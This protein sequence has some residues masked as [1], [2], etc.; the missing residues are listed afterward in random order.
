VIENLQKKFGEIILFWYNPNIHPKEEYKRRLAV[1]RKV[2]RL[3]NLPLIE[4]D[5]DP[6]KWFEAAAGLENEPEGGRR[7]EI[8]FRM[9]LEKTA[10]TAKETGCNYF[11]ATLTVSPRKPAAL[12]NNIGESLA[13]NVIFLAE[14][15]KKEEGFKKTMTEAKKLNLYRQNYCGCVF[16]QKIESRK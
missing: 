4:G 16:S 10:Q 5:Y 1:V 12:V 3:K 13:E 2:S 14:D 6:E 8:C 9:R 7:C 11:A 15:F